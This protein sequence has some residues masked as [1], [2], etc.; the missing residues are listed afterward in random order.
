MVGATS[1]FDVILDALEEYVKALNDFEGQREQ[2]QHQCEDDED[3]L[4]SGVGQVAVHLVGTW[5]TLAGVD[6]AEAEAVDV[7]LG[8][9]VATSKTGWKRMLMM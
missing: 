3:G 6:G 1:A 5:V 4:L 7:P 2:G 9:Q 8:E